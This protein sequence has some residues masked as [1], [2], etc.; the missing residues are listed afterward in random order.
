MENVTSD[1]LNLLKMQEPVLPGVV[2]KFLGNAPPI[3][4][5]E[6]V[7]ERKAADR[8]T[9]ICKKSSMAYLSQSM[10]EY[11]AHD[12]ALE[13]ALPVICENL[14]NNEDVS[15]V[16]RKQATTFLG[17][18]QSFQQLRSPKPRMSPR[19]IAQN[20][21]VFKVLVFPSP[22]HPIFLGAFV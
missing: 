2:F 5:M 15:A 9:L 3:R 4:I 22:F 12:D 19:S 13:P 8:C 18:V 16:M 7:N 14:R 1:A 10:T 21:K 17:K 6:L 20:Q 11:L